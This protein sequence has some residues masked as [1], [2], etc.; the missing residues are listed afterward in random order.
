[1]DKLIQSDDEEE[2]SPVIVVSFC[3]FAGKKISNPMQRA[4]Y[5]GKK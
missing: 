4:I 1:M 3:E 5:S 2:N